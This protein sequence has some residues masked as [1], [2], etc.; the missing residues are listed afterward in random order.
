M[1]RISI[2]IARSLKAMLREHGLMDAPGLA[3][4]A[5]LSFIPLI[6]LVTALTGLL[7]GEDQKLQ[8][9]LLENLE[10]LP[11]FKTLLLE[12]LQRFIQ[13]APAVG[14]I[15]FV[16][17][18]WW[19]GIFFAAISSIFLKI[20]PHAPRFGFWRHI[21]P[22]IA[23]PILS[24]I[25]VALI[26]A[27]HLV[28]YIPHKPVE[29]QIHPVVWTCLGLW[30]FILLLYRVLLPKGCSFKATMI[31]S[32]ILALAIQVVTLLFASLVWSFPNYRLFYGTLS[33]TV[34][35]LLWL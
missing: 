24:L 31:L 18:L 17:A 15:S 34:L 26:L 16:F 11:W 6:F 21:L 12:R 33:S 35:F 22:W 23:G 5:L 27:G 20:W 8:A 2:L 28:S 13:L 7:L 30:L 14:G 4:Y 32:A 10:T 25:L 19:S 1:K 3:F 9:L 29:Q